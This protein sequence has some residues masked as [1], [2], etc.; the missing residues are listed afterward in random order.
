MSKDRQKQTGKFL[1]RIAENLPEMSAEVMQRWIDDP[2]GLQ[3]YLQGLGQESDLLKFIGT[4]SVP[5]VERAAVSGL[6]KKANVGWTGQNFDRVFKDVVGADIPKL[7]LNI[8]EL[9]KCSVDD[10]ILKELGGKELA[11]IHIVSFLNFLT[12]RPNNPEGIVGYIAYCIGLD[13]EL[14]AVRAH[15]R[16]VGRDWDGVDRHWYVGACSVRFPF[17]WGSGYRVLSRK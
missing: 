13:G 11:G 10:P 15:W 9:K 14:W 6:L 3:D 1:A 7:E 12:E 8:H 4:A 17:E 5:G 16:G 2:K